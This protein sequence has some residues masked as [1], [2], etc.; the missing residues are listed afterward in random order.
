MLAVLPKEYVPGLS[1]TP[2]SSATM[3]V[4]PPVPA[5][6][7][8]REATDACAAIAALSLECVEKGG[9]TVAPAGNPVIDVPGDTPTSPVITVPVPAAVTVEPPNTAKLCAEPSD[10][11]ANAG[12]DAQRSAANPL[13]GNRKRLCFIKPHWTTLARPWLSK[14]THTRACSG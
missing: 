11:C 6:V 14:R 2:P 5:R 3:G 8:Y 1:V 12:E 7:A 4:A 10:G 13:A 9:T